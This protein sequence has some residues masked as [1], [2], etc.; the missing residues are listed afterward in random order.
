MEKIKRPLIAHFLDISQASAYS[1]AEWARLGVN[2]TEASTEYNPQNETSQ[3]IVS[4]SATTEITGYQPSM[5]VSQ[6]CTKGDPVFELVTKLRRMRATLADSHSWVLN[7]DLWDKK[8]D[9]E[10]ASYAAEVQE[11][12]IQVDTYGGAGGEAPVQEYT[13]NYVGDPIPG[14]VTMSGGTPSFT[15][16]T[17]VSQEV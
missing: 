1:A 13:L 17:A 3:D 5:P 9:G 14:T 7:V 10:S 8:G 6:Q 2:V 16:G 15:A 4:D 12:S 11:V